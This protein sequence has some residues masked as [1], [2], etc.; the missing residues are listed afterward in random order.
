MGALEDDRDAYVS[1]RPRHMVTLT[2][3]FWMGKYPV[4][5]ALWEGVKGVNRSVFKGSNRLSGEYQ[6]V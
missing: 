4:T 1:E 2:Q 3:G 5:Q 6:L